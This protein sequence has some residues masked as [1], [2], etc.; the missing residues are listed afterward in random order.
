MTVIVS[1]AAGVLL[2]LLA[3]DR[4]VRGLDLMRPLSLLCIAVAPLRAMDTVL[5]SAWLGNLD[6]SVVASCCSTTLG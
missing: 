1:L 2:Q 3:L 5:S 6:F 4:R